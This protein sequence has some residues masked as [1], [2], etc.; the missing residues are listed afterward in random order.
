VL[1]AL[2]RT[3]YTQAADWDFLFAS[4]GQ[5]ALQI[6]G[7]Q[8]CD[9]IVSDMRMPGM[10]GAELLARVRVAW[11][12]AIRIVL[13][14]HADHDCAG[15]AVDSVHRFLSKPCDAALL[16]AACRRS[17]RLRQMLWTAEMRV[18]LARLAPAPVLPGRHVDV[19]VRL[20]SGS[21][22]TTGLDGWD[23]PMAIAEH[24][25]DRVRMAMLQPSAAMATP[26]DGSMALGTGLTRVVVLG[27]Q[28]FSALSTRPVRVP[29]LPALPR[30]GIRLA[31]LAH[32]VGALLGLDARTCEEAFLAGL[33]RDV[34]AWMLRRNLPMEHA[35][36]RAIAAAQAIPVAA[37][38]LQ[39]FGFP[40]ETIAA[41]LLCMWGLPDAVVEAV[42]HVRTPGRAGDTSVGALACVHL[43]AALGEARRR[44]DA[45]TQLDGEFV[46][47]VGLG[48]H[49]T[50][51]RRQLVPSNQGDM[52]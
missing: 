37:A 43:A 9:V 48:E 23:E 33:L 38:Q 31:M 44:G 27:A 50:L 10:D 18:L 5:E 45:R 7:R 1:C 16:L 12:D 34:G 28:V 41:A 49:M 14:G 22:P 19:V 29:G 26:R 24:L 40:S 13:S 15:R 11:P 4:S 25:R 52:P 17:L 39:V 21:S 2:R 30:R 42:A 36:S 8:P 20:T 47:R 32:R 35:R 51:L 6:L 46:A 3:L